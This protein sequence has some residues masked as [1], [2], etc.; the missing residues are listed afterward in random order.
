MMLASIEPA[1]SGVDLYTF[2]C[3][4]CNQVLTT[5]AAYEDPMKSKG[6]WMRASRRFARTEVRRAG[7]NRRIL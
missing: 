4:V 7:V 6:P 1:R 3:A 5:L 2:E